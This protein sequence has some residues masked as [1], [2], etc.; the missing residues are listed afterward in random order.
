MLC[1]GST[2]CSL[3]LIARRPFIVSLLAATSTSCATNSPHTQRSWLFWLSFSWHQSIAIELCNFAASSAQ[4]VSLL[5]KLVHL[6]IKVFWFVH[7]VTAQCWSR[8]RTFF[9]SYNNLMKAENMTSNQVWRTPLTV[10]VT[11]NLC[12]FI[13]HGNLTSNFILWQTC[14]CPSINLSYI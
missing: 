7:C 5:L 9:R 10:F 4:V 2:R 11:S 12:Q 1:S 8:E 13:S 14:S 3:V 6:L